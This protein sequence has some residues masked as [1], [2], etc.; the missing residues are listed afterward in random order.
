MHRQS[1][2][3]KARILIVSLKYSP[4]LGSFRIVS[5][6]SNG[7]SERGFKITVLT[8]CPP[9][10]EW[11][12]V[13]NSKPINIDRKPRIEVIRVAI[14]RL[15]KNL[16]FLSEVMNHIFSPFFFTLSIPLIV[17]KFDVVLVFSPPLPLYFWSAILAKLARK[18]VLSYVNDIHPRALVEIG[19]IKSKFEIRI[20]EIIE[21][22]AYAFTDLIITHSIGAR[23]VVLYKTSSDC[24]IVPLW[25]N[26]EELRPGPRMNS[27]RENIGKNK[28]IVT[29]AGLMSYSQDLF[30]I[31]EAASYFKNDTSIVFVLAGKGPEK[32]LLLERVKEL[33]L[34]NVVFLPFLNTDEYNQL[35]NASD[36]MLVPLKSKVKTTVIPSKIF[37]IMAVGKPMILMVPNDNDAV[38]IVKEL[39]CG[40]HVQPENPAELYKAILML[41]SD[42]GTLTKLGKN[43]YV[44]ARIYSLDSAVEKM[45][46][47]IMTKL[48]DNVSE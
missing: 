43:S 38:T 1:D 35:C 5:E 24:A 14:P 7:L 12:L 27:I 32:G 44:A 45:E 34:N 18:P 15:K 19:L 25:A 9:K 26:S 28:F 37:D 8:S 10:D 6:L 31:I 2:N 46:K 39:E 33:K 3:L 16:A 20:L 47:L 41:K 40:V 48:R 36:L 30:T 13:C 4:E 29:F 11:P 23:D 42:L 17:R 22:L 21:Y